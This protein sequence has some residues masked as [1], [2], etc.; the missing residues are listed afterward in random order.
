MKYPI[1]ANIKR[2]IIGKN[3]FRESPIDNEVEEG[4]P[5]DVDTHKA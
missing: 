4:A 1:I 5:L 3:I 2:A